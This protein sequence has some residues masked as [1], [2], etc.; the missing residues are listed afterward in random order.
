MESSDKCVREHVE[1]VDLPFIIFDRG[2]KPSKF[3]SLILLLTPHQI[4]IGQDIM[5]VT[6]IPH[7]LKVFTTPIVTFEETQV[8]IRPKELRA[9]S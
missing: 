3:L 9:L 5:L 8:V 6:N 4:G 2:I 1:H 7:A